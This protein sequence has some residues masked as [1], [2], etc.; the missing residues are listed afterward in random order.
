MAAK[1]QPDLLDYPRT[2]GWRT[3]VTSIEAA[4]AI[5]PGAKLLRDKVLRAIR[6]AGAFGLTADE[7]A[8]RL[9]LTPFTARPRCTELNKLGEIMDSGLRRENESGRRAIVWI[10]VG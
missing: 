7:A 3:P 4:E 6:A 5:A 9:G 1:Q 10:V 2:P 8:A